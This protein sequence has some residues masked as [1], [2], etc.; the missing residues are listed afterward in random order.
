MLL[1]E[2]DSETDEGWDALE[3]I[4]RECT[5]LT[6][7][8]VWEAD[9]LATWKLP[10]LT[11]LRVRSALPAEQFEA[12]MDAV[13][14]NAPRLRSLRLGVI[15]GITTIQPIGSTTSIALMLLL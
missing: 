14:T 10:Q 3:D 1:D 5:S 15:S 7:L 11:L 12:F 2:Y 4:V 9:L 6:D 8:D 13:R